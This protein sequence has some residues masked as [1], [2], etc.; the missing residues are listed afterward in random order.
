MGLM[1]IAVFSQAGIRQKMAD[2]LLVIQQAL[3]FQEAT[4]LA[5]D[6][7]GSVDITLP[8]SP[9]PQSIPVVGLEPQEEAVPREEESLEVPE[10]IGSET[11]SM[12]EPSQELSLAEIREEVAEVDREVKLVSQ[13]VENLLKA[14]E[15][16]KILEQERTQQLVEIAQQVQE[17]AQKVETI[18]SQVARL[19]AKAPSQSPVAIEAGVGLE[20]GGINL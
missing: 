16:Q 19:Q 7:L 2:L 17:I 20:G 9:Q 4:P 10:E 6:S 1:V 14:K 11:G 15:Q 13:G 12:A 5:L 8:E 3:L 18:S